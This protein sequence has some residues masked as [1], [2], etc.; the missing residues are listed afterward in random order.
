M[1]HA[2]NGRRLKVRWR[3]ALCL[4]VLLLAPEAGAFSPSAHRII[5]HIAE[6]RLKPEVKRRIQNDF[7]IKSLA[8]V[9]AWADTVRK[10][11]AQGPWH[12]ANVREGESAYLKDRDCP[13]GECVVEKIPHFKRILEDPGQPPGKRREALMYLVHFVGDVHQPL[14]LGNLSDRGG[15]RISLTYRGR[16]TNLH[17][18]WDGGLI[19]RRGRSLLQYAQ[20][21]DGRVRPR[22][23]AEWREKDVGEWANESRRLALSAAYGPLPAGSGRLDKRYIVTARQIIDQRLA[24]AGVRLAQ[25]L[26]TA[27]AD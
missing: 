15:N 17:A 4:A 13:T 9:A 19:H 27:L 23:A 22:D 8:D 18:L 24:Q 2:L 7:S 11:L 6:G 20:D 21:L 5:A 14:H 1:S 10:R 16:M 26:N 3:I 12:Y 25:M